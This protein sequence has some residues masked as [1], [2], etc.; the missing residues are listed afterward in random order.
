MQDGFLVEDKSYLR[1]SKRYVVDNIYG[2]L[3][4]MGQKYPCQMLDIS[5]GG[6]MLCTA[7]SFRAGALATVEFDFLYDGCSFQLYGMT[8]WTK[9]DRNIGIR[10]LHP[11]D[12][13]RMMVASLVER[14][15]AHEAAALSSAAV[16]PPAPTPKAPP[17]PHSTAKILP[18]SRLSLDFVRAVHQ[19]AQ[20]VLSKLQTDWTAE[21][22]FID[23]GTH[24]SSWVLDFSLRGCSVQS[25]SPLEVECDSRIQMVFQIKDQRF[26][27]AGLPV[28]LDDSHTLGIKFI[29]ISDRR[30][31][32]LN[33][34]IL[35]LRAS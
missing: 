21:L 5:L 24:A 13:T 34:L 11:T 1:A 32:F 3:H 25:D 29:D 9:S 14:I 35:N 23:H 26:L 8:E 19:G 20:R 30:R 28:G 31:Q 15:A 10:F 18:S 17:S 22:L 2:E 4:Y 33:R 7:K 6:C 12:A 27:L 16:N